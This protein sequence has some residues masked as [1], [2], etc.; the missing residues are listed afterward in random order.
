MVV[1]DM[2]FALAGNDAL[3]YVLSQPAGLSLIPLLGNCYGGLYVL[4]TTS[5][6]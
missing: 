6:L 4:S 5:T 2:D 1:R 3:M